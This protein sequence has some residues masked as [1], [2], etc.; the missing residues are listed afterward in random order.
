MVAYLLFWV[1]KYSLQTIAIEDKYER[2]HH[3]VAEVRH[4][5]TIKKL[6]KR[7]KAAFRH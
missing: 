2:Y 6:L 7:I 1:G 3:P 4:K 5:L